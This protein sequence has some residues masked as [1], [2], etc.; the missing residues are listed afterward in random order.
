M[1]IRCPEIL[2]RPSLAGGANDLGIH[3]CIVDAIM[4][5]DAS[6]RHELASNV[7]LSGGNTM[8]P[9][10]VERLERELLLEFQ[11]RGL[12]V[13]DQLLPFLMSTHERLGR[14]CARSLRDVSKNPTLS[15][16]IASF[17][18]CTTRVIAQP[19][20]QMSAWA[21]GALQASVSLKSE[22]MWI[23][24]QGYRARGVS[25]LNETF[26]VPWGAS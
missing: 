16:S 5:C 23:S 13:S 12:G 21:G 6:I 18:P 1:P 25:V 2:F 15:R 17:I 9:G 4:S 14:G 7:C 22:N 19:D 26:P 24:C 20:R 10:L 3:Q 11:A 8:F